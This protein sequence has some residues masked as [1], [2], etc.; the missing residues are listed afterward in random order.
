MD[1]LKLAAGWLRF[2]FGLASM[3]AAPTLACGAGD[4]ASCSHH[5]H[6]HFFD[7][8]TMCRWYRTAHGPN[9]IWRPLSAY[10]VPRP[11]DPC[12]YGGGRCY[13][14]GGYE[15]AMNFEDFSED[16]AEYDR[17]ELPAY[18]E[19]PEIPVGLERLGRIPNDLGIS[20]GAAAPAR[21][22]R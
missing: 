2:V 12:K 17:A 21:P 20:A 3:V 6:A 13:G 5:G 18:A 9:S 16:S 7:G 19:S 1:A 8:T 22:G 4:C 14:P 11:A 10:Y 15:I